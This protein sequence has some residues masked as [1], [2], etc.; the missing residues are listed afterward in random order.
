MLHKDSVLY[1]DGEFICHCAENPLRRKYNPELLDIA[2]LSLQLIVID[3]RRR[4]DYIAL[5]CGLITIGPQPPSNPAHPLGE[6]HAAAF[7]DDSDSLVS[8]HSSDLSLLS[9][10]SSSHPSAFDFHVAEMAGRI[11]SLELELHDMENA[12]CVMTR[13]KEA[14]EKRLQEMEEA[15]HTDDQGKGCIGSQTQSLPGRPLLPSPVHE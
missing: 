3:N 7:V 2:D 8:F 1:V 9:T 11:T 6:P 15:L 4:L 12:L 14:G 13:E 5:A 10:P